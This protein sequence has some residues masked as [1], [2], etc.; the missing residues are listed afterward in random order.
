MAI[1]ALLLLVFL[2]VADWT[3]HRSGND[4]AAEDAS[5]V[6]C[7]APTHLDGLVNA[8]A[9]LGLATAG[10]T[11]GTLRVDGR[12]LT[13]AR[14]RAADGGDFRR[15]CDAYATT[16]LPAGA[17][18]G[19]PDAS[20]AGLQ[21]LLDILLP[22]I[23]GALLT[24]AADDLKQA[25]DRR[26]AQGDELRADWRG[27][28]D[29]VDSWMAEAAEN[30]GLPDTSDIESKQ[31]T[32]EATLRKIQSQHRGSSNIRELCD[33]YKKLGASL[34]L[35]DGW[36]DPQGKAQMITG[37]ISS[38]RALLERVA[39]ALERRIWPP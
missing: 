8:A 16:G 23:A 24:M 21:P 29:A 32:L 31:R 6:Y 26:W 18:S 11:P 2:V 17:E 4:A 25:A 33:S 20:A 22:V 34:S 37:S 36:D 9:S 15:A 19:G 12:Q 3:I 14:W 35:T 30:R 38:F 39:G 1:Y 10:A 7:L 13:L 27:F 28:E 5:V